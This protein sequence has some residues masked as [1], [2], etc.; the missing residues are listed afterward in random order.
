MTD[1]D[2]PPLFARIALIGIGLIGSSLAHVIRRHGLAEHIA[3]AARSEESLDVAR[4]LGLADSVSLDPGR[5]AQDAD[6]VVICSPLG[7]YRAIGEAIAPHLKAGAILT[8]VGSV[9]QV[10]I[11]NLADRSNRW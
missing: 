3:I 10:V 8:D 4:E 11:K 1:G 7:T 5:V 6:L 2:N 9:K